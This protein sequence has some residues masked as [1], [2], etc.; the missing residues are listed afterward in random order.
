MRALQIDVTDISTSSPFAKE[1]VSC[2]SA[3]VDDVVT[4][5]CF[6]YPARLAPKQLHDILSGV[7]SRALSVNEA[8]LAQINKAAVGWWPSW[9]QI[10]LVRRRY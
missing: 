4:V 10:C 5:S 6:I 2:S 8:S 3:S 9:I 1:P 7:Q